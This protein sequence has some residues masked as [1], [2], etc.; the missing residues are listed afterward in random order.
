M[1]KTSNVMI[2]LGLLCCALSA[3]ATTSSHAGSTCSMPGSP[4]AWKGYKAVAALL[5]DDPNA[6]CNADCAVAMTTNTNVLISSASVLYRNNGGTNYYVPPTS[7][8]LYGRSST[9]T[10][11][12][13]SQKYA[14]PTA[15]GCSP[16]P[17]PPFFLGDGKLS[18]TNPFGAVA[19]SSLAGVAFS[20][21]VA[22][23]SATNGDAILYGYSLTY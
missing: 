15:G 1:K 22:N 12:Y 17:Q 14:C 6:G 11:Y 2:V 4:S 13:S 16:E 7:C 3:H 23:Y 20:C 8:T 21:S 9:N 10:L 5:C 18:W 19:L